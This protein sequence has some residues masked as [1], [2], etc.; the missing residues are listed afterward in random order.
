VNKYNTKP[1]E[2]ILDFLM[3]HKNKRFTVKQMYEE[4]N[5]NGLDVNLA[6]I[7]RNVD[8]LTKE[9]KL[10]KHQDVENNFA[11]YQFIMDESCLAHFHFECK[12]CGSM[13]HLPKKETNDFLKVIERTLFFTVDPQNTYLTGICSKCRKKLIVV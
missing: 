10:L 5:K 8:R 9:G 3:N 1:K 7:Y 6:T 11:T 12:V 13:I 2:Y 4:I